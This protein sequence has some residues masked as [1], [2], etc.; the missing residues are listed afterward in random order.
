MSTSLRDVPLDLSSDVVSL[1][2]ALVDIESVSH[3]EG[4]ITDAVEAALRACPNLSVERDGNVVLA[5]TEFGRDERVALAGHLDTV[6]I[7]DNLPSRREG[8]RLYGCGSADMKSGVAVMLR[9]AHLVGTGAL[10]PRV[11]LT[12]VAYDC[13]EVE[14]ASN[15]LGRVARENPDKLACDLAVLLEPSA[16]LVEG[17]CQGT[18][19]AVVR[20]EGVRAHSARSWLGVNAIHAA[21]AVMQRLEDYEPR[22]VEV[23]GLSYREGLNAVFISGGVAGNII[24]DECLVTVNYR[25]APDL[26]EEQAHAHVRDVFSG[27]SVEIVDSAP[28]ARPGLD[29]ALAQSLVAAVGGEP[30]AKLGWTDVARFGE[31][32]IPAVNFGPG[33]PDLAHKREEWVAVDAI[34]ESEAAMIRFLSHHSHHSHHSHGAD[35]G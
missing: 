16:G 22:T 1:T 21:G 30:R 14:A 2:A 26:D 31:L 29:G 15:G 33:D 7:A 32:G 28:S 11:D 8:D 4:A 9:I 23:E 5:R 3:D 27:Y 24:P 25:F 35:D 12:W 17:G 34:V 13:E 20:T 6:P 10:D 19:R 18:M